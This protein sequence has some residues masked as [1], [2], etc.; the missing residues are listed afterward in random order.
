MNKSQVRFGS[1]EVKQVKLQES[2]FSIV[3]WENWCR[4][5]LKSILAKESMSL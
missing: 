1:C 2:E 5:F 3:K 4:L